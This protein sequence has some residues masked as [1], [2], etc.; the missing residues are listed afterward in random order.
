MM[1]ARSSVA[2]T[3]Q[4][5]CDV[6]LAEFLSRVAMAREIEEAVK[7]EGVGGRA[8]EQALRSAWAACD[9]L[10]REVAVVRPATME[11]VRAKAAAFLWLDGHAPIEDDETR[12]RLVADVMAFLAGEPPG[13][14]ED[15]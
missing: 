2:I 13:A 10:A 3:D 9:A 12:A 5:A 6:L 1:L 4:S 11:V 8:R 15:R 14:P 7:R